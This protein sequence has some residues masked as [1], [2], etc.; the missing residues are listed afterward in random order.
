MTTTTRFLNRFGG[1]SWAVTWGPGLTQTIICTSE[2]EAA[3]VASRGRQDGKASS[4]IRRASGFHR[5]AILL[6]PRLP[7]RRVGQAL[8]L[9]QM[10]WSLQQRQGRQVRRLLRL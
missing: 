6:L 10:R 7:R 8:R 9:R 2:E 4:P 5:R 3:E 1:F